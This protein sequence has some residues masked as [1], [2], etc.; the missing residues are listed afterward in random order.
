[1]QSMRLVSLG[2]KYRLPRGSANLDSLKP[3]S[4][5]RQ[6]VPQGRRS[7]RLPGRLQPENLGK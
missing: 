4:L 5:G 3:V 7:G 2:A 1:M 6:A